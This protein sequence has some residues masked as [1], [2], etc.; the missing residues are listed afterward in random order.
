MTDDP[1]LRAFESLIHEAFPIQRKH[2][3]GLTAEEREIALAINE[4]AH[5]VCELRDLV[6]LMRSS[7]AELRAARIRREGFK[8]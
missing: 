6:A 5:T 2:P 7:L 1:N 8:P 3:E 4:L